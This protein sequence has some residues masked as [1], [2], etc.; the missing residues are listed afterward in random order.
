MEQHAYLQGW[1]RAV[2]KKGLIHHVYAPQLGHPRP[3]RDLAQGHPAP[4]RWSTSSLRPD[5]QPS[6]AS[7]T[8]GSPTPHLPN[9]PILQDD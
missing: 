2:W 8:L 1:D 9:N 6:T 4:A 3:S 5:Q 7:V